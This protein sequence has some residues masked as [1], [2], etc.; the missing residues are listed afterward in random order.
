MLWAAALLEYGYHPGC[1]YLFLPCSLCLAGLHLFYRKALSKERWY[2][3]RRGSNLAFGLST[4]LFVIYSTAQILA[5]LPSAAPAYASS[6]PA[7][8]EAFSRVATQHSGLPGLLRKAGHWFAERTVGTKILLVSAAIIITAVCIFFWAFICLCLLC[9]GAAEA[10]VYTLM[11]LGSALLAFICI[12]IIQSILRGEP[13]KRKERLQ[14]GG[15]QIF[16]FKRRSKV[17]GT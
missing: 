10:L 5:P 2:W 15:T 8:P 11:F 4:F 6:I 17:P 14:A 13:L 1:Y 12:R 9:D 16:R 7:K 3:Y